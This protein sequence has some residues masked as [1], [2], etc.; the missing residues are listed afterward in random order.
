MTWRIETPT[1][2]MYFLSLEGVFN[3]LEEIRENTKEPVDMSGASDSL[4]R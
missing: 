3:K 1:G 4:D 2:D